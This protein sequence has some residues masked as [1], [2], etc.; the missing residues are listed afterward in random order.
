MMTNSF[1]SEAA[2]ERMANRLLARYEDR[3]GT[4]D[5]PPV[6]VES[7]LENILDLGILWDTVPEKPGQSI[8]AGLDPN[9][10][11]VVFNETRLEL[12]EETPG[13]YN[14]ILAHEAGHWEAHFDPALLDRPRC[15]SSTASSDACIGN[16]DPAETPGKGKPISSWAFCSCLRICC[17]K[18]S[19]M[20]ICS[21]GRTFTHCATFSR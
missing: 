13:L 8:L 16:P 1:L 4:I 5:Y 18:P 20:L 3:Y 12:I 15:R 6:P 7:V 10:R 9:N 21:A 17:A 19:E 11:T 2:L 14:T